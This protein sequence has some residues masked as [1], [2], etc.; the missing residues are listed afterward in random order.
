MRDILTSKTWRRW[1]CC[2]MAVMS[3]CMM[4]M[5]SACMNH[6]SNAKTNGGKGMLEV[7]AS[8]VYKDPAVVQLAEA[9]VRGDR[10]AIH[11]LARQGVDVN[12]Q[13]DLDT[14]VLQWAFWNQSIDGM[15][16]L[17]EVGANPAL[18]DN[19][20]LTVMHYGAAIDDPKLLQALLD[21][22]VDPDVR[23]S[24]GQPPIFDAILHDREPQFRALLAAGADLN[25]QENIREGL[26]ETGKRPLHRAAML[27][28][29][30]RIL[31]LLEAGADPRA[32]DGL[33]STFQPILNMMNESIALDSF[34][35]GK[36]KIEAWLVEHGIELEG[37][38]G[39]E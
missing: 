39:G 20:G 36:R 24:K 23:N 28:D 4:A 16:A 1:V 17:L 14:S 29:V 35:T 12:T 38:R 6:E 7:T 9:A 32:V 10:Q 2:R 8:E 13:G 30:E 3:L 22:G 31:A 5:L 25:A 33:G 21:A 26:T 18:M 11:E 27:N 37:K 34:V 19:K 15:R